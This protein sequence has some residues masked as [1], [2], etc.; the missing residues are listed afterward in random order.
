M[1]IVADFWL[2][3]LL[4][5]VGYVPVK[6]RHSV[7]CLAKLQANIYSSESRTVPVHLPFYVVISGM[8]CLWTL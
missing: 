7:V 8:N 1:E 5:G 6:A 4:Q 2:A 3:G